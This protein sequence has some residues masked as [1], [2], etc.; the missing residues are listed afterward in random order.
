MKTIVHYYQQFRIFLGPERFLVL[1]ALF[2]GTGLFSTALA[3]IQTEWAGTAQTLVTLLF[4]AVAVILI[5]G[6]MEGDAR[7]R[8]GAILAPAVGLL[9][10][11]ALFLPQY[12]LAAAGGAVGWIAAGAMIFGKS[13]APMQYRQAVKA[14]RKNDYDAAVKAMDSLIKAEPQEP[15]HYRFRAELLRLWGKTDRARRDYQQ[16]TTLAQDDAT[17]AVA[18]NGLAEIDLQTGKYEAAREAAQKACDLAPGEWVAAYN[19]GLI[20]DRVSDAP[21]AID[22]LNRA[23]AAKIP[24][25]RHRL[26][27]YLYLLRAHSRRQDSAAATH[28]LAL[29]RKERAG[30]REWQSILHSDQ[31]Q[32]LR[33]VLAA[34]IDTA[35]RLMDGELAP[36]ALADG[37][38]A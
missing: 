23:L 37:R 25:S 9:L 13:R 19:L 2:I 30:L 29:L 1:V 12:G 5:V 10:L 38:P 21:G 34:D 18:F 14:M 8:W 22:S 24:D 20:Q 6:R 36:A 33:D 4:L 7:Y 31:A 26:L 28:T 17:R 11:A 3:T 32:V 27:V 15:N 16:M 35:R